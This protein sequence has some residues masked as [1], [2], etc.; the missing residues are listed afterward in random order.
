MVDVR[1]EVVVLVACGALALACSS[2][3][4]ASDA[5]SDAP[6]PPADGSTADTGPVDDGGTSCN[7]PVNG[8][9]ASPSGTFTATIVNTDANLS[10]PMPG[11]IPCEGTFSAM[12]GISLGNNQYTGSFGLQCW[13]A[14]GTLYFGMRLGG[15][16]KPKA[17]D[18]YPIGRGASFAQADGGYAWNGQAELAWEEG[19][20]CD[21]K[22]NQSKEWNGEA[23]MGKGGKLFIDAVSGTDVT[24][25]VTE[26]SLTTSMTGLNYKGTGSFKVSGMGTVKLVGL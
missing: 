2:G 5:G 13:G 22:Q 17:G 24:F 3:G 26:T 6:S 14:D 19:P 4:S 16:T 18:S 25:H 21:T 1:R 23:A 12:G 15:S 7:P 9:V 20:R 11:A 10:K 8:V